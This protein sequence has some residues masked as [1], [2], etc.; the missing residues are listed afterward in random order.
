MIVLGSLFAAVGIVS[1]MIPGILVWQLTV[2]VGLLN[3][4]G[5][6]VGLGEN[7]HSP[8]GKNR[9]SLGNLGRQY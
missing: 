4:S 7:I 2:L 5:G 8:A 1:C 3:I 9:K 6:T